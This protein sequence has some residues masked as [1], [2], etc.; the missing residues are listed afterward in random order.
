M[1]LSEESAI[2][3]SKYLASLFPE[4][5]VNMMTKLKE[6]TIDVGPQPVKWAKFTQIPWEAVLRIIA[7]NTGDGQQNL[8]GM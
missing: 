7:T 1:K 8:S 6:A 4:Q 3:M 2:A 5:I